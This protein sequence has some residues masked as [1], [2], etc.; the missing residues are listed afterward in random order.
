MLVVR[1]LLK[2]LRK[3]VVRGLSAF[4]EKKEIMEVSSVPLKQRSTLTRCI[5]LLH[6]QCTK[7]CYALL[8]HAL[9]A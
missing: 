4:Y 2:K 6:K 1:Y 5:Y 8:R 3:A 7:F 9:F